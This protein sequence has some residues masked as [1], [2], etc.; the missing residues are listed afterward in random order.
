LGKASEQAGPPLSASDPVIRQV[1]GLAKSGAPATKNL[2]KFLTSWRKTKGFQYLLRTIFGLSGSLNAFDQYGHFLRGLVPLQNCFDYTSTP[3]SGCSAKFPGSLDTTSKIAL[4]DDQKRPKR[5]KRDEPERRS[6]A[7][8]EKPGEEVESSASPAPGSPSAPTPPTAPAEPDTEVAPAPDV[9]AAPRDPDA[10]TESQG[11]VGTGSG[12]RLRAAR[13]I[14]DFLIG[15]TP[16]K[17]RGGG[18]R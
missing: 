17:R 12:P 14:L 9:D 8:G 18:K 5:A 7:D 4:A 3:Q 15:E 11:E 10:A 6:E 2:A 1:R 13:N 16:Q